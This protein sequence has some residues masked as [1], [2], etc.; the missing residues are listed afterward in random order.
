LAETVARKL[1]QVWEKAHY[2][3]TP[4][5]KKLE[6]KKEQQELS[7]EERETLEDIANMFGITIYVR[8]HKKG[9]LVNIKH[10]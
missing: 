2:R 7:K 8:P 9:A 5:K 6:T 3:Y 10:G 1:Q 4:S